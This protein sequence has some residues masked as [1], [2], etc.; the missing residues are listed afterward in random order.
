MADIALQTAITDIVDL[1]TAETDTALVL[2]PDG[3]GGVEFRA[4][5]G[6]GGGTPTGISLTKL[7]VQAAN[8]GTSLSVTISAAASGQRLIVCVSSYNR[9]VNTPTC[10]NVT[11]TEVLAANFSTGAYLSVYVGVVA[12]GSSGTSIAITATGSDWIIAD[13][14]EVADALT[15]T[16]GSS[17]TLTDTDASSKSRTAI[18]NVS[19][20][21]GDFY[22]IAAAQNSGSGG[23][24][25]IQ[26]NQPGI[27]TGPRGGND[28]LTSRIGRATSSKI[29][30]FYTG[31]T[32]G[33]DM[34]A[35]IVI[36]S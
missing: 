29:T 13:V 17:A 22:I 11:F 20:S 5:T 3:A 16:A 35:G 30:G 26:S 4:E 25:V 19:A 36:V 33:G 24:G 28:A 32:S 18:G 2:A 23:F 8:Q 34:A 10:T 31:G 27:D 6:G 14:Y 1:P 21:A 12:G 7:Y 9:D 15:P